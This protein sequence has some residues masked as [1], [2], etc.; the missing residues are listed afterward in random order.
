M[1]EVNNNSSLIIKKTLKISKKSQLKDN[2]SQSKPKSTVF[3]AEQENANVISISRA[4]IIE[5]ENQAR[6]AEEQRRQQNPEKT[7]NASNLQDSEKLNIILENKEKI[8]EKI[9]SFLLT[10]KQWPIYIVNRND[11]LDHENGR[12]MILIG[13][14]AIPGTSNYS[15]KTNLLTDKTQLLANSDFIWTVGNV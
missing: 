9:V 1:I 3:Y 7:S 11:S 14:I 13:N 2:A 12:P 6:K 15:G 10:K 8:F 5:K 4:K